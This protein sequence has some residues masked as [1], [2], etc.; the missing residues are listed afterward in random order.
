MPSFEELKG[1]SSGGNQELGNSLSISATEFFTGL[2]ERLNSSEDARRIQKG[3]NFDPNEQWELNG[4][5]EAVI[6]FL[7]TGVT[8]NGEQQKA[9][10]EFFNRRD[11]RRYDGEGPM[12]SHR[13]LDKGSLWALVAAI[14]TSGT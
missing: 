11:H 7:K 3:K 9:I 13:V 14:N 8:L 12:G 5:A 10:L 4:V 2:A 6:P 1:P